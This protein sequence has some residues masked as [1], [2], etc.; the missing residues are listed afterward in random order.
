MVA[1][2]VVLLWVLKRFRWLCDRY[3]V[4]LAVYCIVR[5]PCAELRRLMMPSVLGVPM[6]GWFSTLNASS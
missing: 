1:T 3:Q 4:S 6:P 2:T 5:A